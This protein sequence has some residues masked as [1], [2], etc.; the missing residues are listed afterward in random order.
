MISKST[1]MKKPGINGKL[2]K[3]KGEENKRAG[4]AS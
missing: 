1:E 2:M 4:S 3:K